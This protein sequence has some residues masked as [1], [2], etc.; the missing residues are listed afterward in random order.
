[1]SEKVFKFGFGGDTVTVALPAAQVIHEIEGR[2]AQPIEDVTAAINDALRRPI[3]APPLRQIVKPGETVA[4]VASDITRSW[5]RADI[6][7]PVLLDELN[8]AGIPDKDIFLVVALGAHRPHTAAEN[9]AVY[10]SE[11]C[12]RVRIFQHDAGNQAELV[13]CGVTS[14]GVETW[15]NKKV[16]EAD[17]VIITGGIV[18]HLMAGFGAGRK[19]IMPGVSGYDTIQANHRFC[20]SPVVGGG[21]N[22]HCM[23]GRT[24]GNEMHEDQMEITALVE[25]DFLLNVVFTPEGRFAGIFAGHWQTAWEAGCNMVEQIYGIPITAQ[26]DLVIA[27]AGGFPKDINLYQGAKSIDNAYLATRP[28]GVAICFLECRDIAEPAEF[29]EWF[30]YDSALDMELA[31]RAGFTVPGFIAL[32]CSG[33]AADISLIIV[34]KPENA[35]FIRKTG[36]IPACSAEEALRIAKEKIGWNDFT[37]TV[38]PHAANT[39][40]LLSGD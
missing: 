14:R 5:A 15:I 20:L 1:M 27:S 12:K 24:A 11:V 23:S 31:L 32:R 4:I 34:T 8:E 9:E 29:S 16:K 13:Y 21:I 37:I 25:P 18:Y 7:L 35:D 6:F 30:R 19:A 38:M 28:G 22:P 36:M 3:G 17:R 10:G 33:I 26:A 40:P 2:P 39:V